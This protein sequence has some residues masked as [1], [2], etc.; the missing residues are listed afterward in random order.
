[1]RRALKFTG[2][3][4]VCIFLVS[5]CEDD[6]SGSR[7][8][9]TYVPQ[10]YVGWIKV[11]YNVPG[12]QPLPKD[13]LG[14]WQY[15]SI[16][17][18]GLLRTSDTVSSHAST[19]IEYYYGDRASANRMPENLVHEG[20]VSFLIDDGKGNSIKEQFR[21]TFIGS[22]DVYEQHKSELKLKQVSPYWFAPTQE[23]YLPPI[24]NIAR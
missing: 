17:E 8:T 22:T 14:A 16:P 2:L 12:A 11:E 3:V 1:M 13:L 6:P 15:I 10:G 24:G 19:T 23:D 7:P 21:L 5:A 20:V 4:I 9:K 18:T